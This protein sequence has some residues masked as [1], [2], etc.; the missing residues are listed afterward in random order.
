MGPE[1]ITPPARKEVY[2]ALDE[3]VQAEVLILKEVALND[4]LNFRYC[5]IKN[6]LLRLLSI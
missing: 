1:N 2:P 5:T 6:K 3:M 4:V